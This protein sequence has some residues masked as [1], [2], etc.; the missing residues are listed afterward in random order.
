MPSI[1]MGKDDFLIRVSPSIDEEHN[2]TG[3]IEINMYLSSSS[4]L[5]EEDFNNL[6][7]LVKTICASV[8]LYE[9]NPDLY[10]EACKYVQFA[11]GRYEPA[12]KEEV[13]FKNKYTTEGSVINVDFRKHEQGSG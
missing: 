13:F 4:T 10:D 8:P 7:L 2:W 1:D 5:C 12:K 6:T 9:E 3:E 11:E